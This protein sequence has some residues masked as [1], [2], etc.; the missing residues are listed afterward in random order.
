MKNT[1]IRLT[2]EKCSKIVAALECMPQTDRDPT[3]NQLYDEIKQVRDIW[4]NIDIKAF[5]RS[6]MNELAKS[7]R[8]S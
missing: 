7:K 1:S 6:Q 2:D 4:K 3:W 5:H 8:G